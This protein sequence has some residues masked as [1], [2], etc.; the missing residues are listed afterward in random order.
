MNKDIVVLTELV[1]HSAEASKLLIANAIEMEN[2]E[3]MNAQKYLKD[4]K[5]LL[6]VMVKDIFVEVKEQLNSDVQD[7]EDFD[8]SVLDLAKLLANVIYNASSLITGLINSDD[9][10]VINIIK[11][12]LLKYINAVEE[13]AQAILLN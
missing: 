4:A 5:N 3:I 7:S 6:S 2:G 1:E 11:N 9:E 8:F 13:L 10:I 12:K